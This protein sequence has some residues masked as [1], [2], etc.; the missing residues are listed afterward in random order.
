MKVWADEKL[1]LKD[2]LSK[3]D[4]LRKYIS[5]EELNGIFENK[6]MLKNVEFIFD[7]TVLREK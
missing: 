4:E 1:N 3:S 7:R 2:E 5:V 6:N